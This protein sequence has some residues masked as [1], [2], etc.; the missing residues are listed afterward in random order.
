MQ[1]TDNNGSR[2]NTMEINKEEQRKWSR[3]VQL[4]VDLMTATPNSPS[5]AELPE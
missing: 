2:D 5:A 4:P 3:A 1:S